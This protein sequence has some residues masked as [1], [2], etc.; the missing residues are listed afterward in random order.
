MSAQTIADV[1]LFGIDTTSFDLVVINA[2]K[3]AIPL[4]CAG[5]GAIFI[6]GTIAKVAF[7]EKYD[8]AMYGAEAKKEIENLDLDNLSAEDAAAVAALEEEMRKSGKL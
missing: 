5:V 1:A 2:I 4:Y 3:L 6:F 7:P 8:K